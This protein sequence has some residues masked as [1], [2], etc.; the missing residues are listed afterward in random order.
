VDQLALFHRSFLDVT[1][2]A[3]PAYDRPDPLLASGHVPRQPVAGSVDGFQWLP[4]SLRQIDLYPK[5][6]QNFEGYSTEWEKR[7]SMLIDGPNQRSRLAPVVD[8]KALRTGFP[9]IAHYGSVHE[10]WIIVPKKYGSKSLRWILDQGVPAYIEFTYPNAGDWGP[11]SNGYVF[12]YR[13]LTDFDGQILAEVG[14]S[15]RDDSIESADPLLYLM[16]GTL[17]VKL[18]ARGGRMILA[19]AARKGAEKVAET[20]AGEIVAQFRSEGKRVVVNVGGTGEVAEAINLNPNIAAPRVGIPNLIKREAEEMGEIFEPNSV[21][22]IVSNS[23]PPNTLDWK[24][25]L[26]GA[27]KV[28]KPGG[29]ITIRFTGIGDDAA[30]ILEQLKRLGFKDIVDFANKGVAIT[31]TR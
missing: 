10:D 12:N 23:L 21:D 27:Q 1:Q 9:L 5:I 18:A 22:E 7:C 3:R 6:S 24:R 17:L 14:S 20:G 30:T 13:V 2:D 25:V 31:A 4:K 28:L 29:K 15:G 11:L 19:L 16:V 26:P 8:H